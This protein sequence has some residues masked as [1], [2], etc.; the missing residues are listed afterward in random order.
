[1]EQWYMNS[2]K[3]RLLTSST[4]RPTLRVVS[5]QT[6]T[7]R[8][9]T[10]LTHRQEKLGKGSSPGHTDKRCMLKTDIKHAVMRHTESKGGILEPRM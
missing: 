6:R 3:C 5:V 2:W 10:S 4:H 9:I 7:C 1:M 8:N